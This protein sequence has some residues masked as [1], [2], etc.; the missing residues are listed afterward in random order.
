MMTSSAELICSRMAWLGQVDAREQH[1][2][3]QAVQCIARAVGVH[4]GQRAIVPRVH[5]LE[6]VEHLVTANLTD[7][8]A[9]GAHTKRVANQFALRDLTLAFDVGRAGLEAH[10]VRLQQLEL[11]GVLD[12]Y[13]TF[14]G[15]NVLGQGVEQRGLTGTGTAGDQRVE[16]RAN[17]AP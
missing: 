10:H 7:D 1:E 4:S 12:G 16:A 3:F 13:D 15:R 14:L 2:C 11:G 17:G 8:D 5:G 6:H 9:V